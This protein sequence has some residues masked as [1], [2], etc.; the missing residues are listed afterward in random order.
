LQLHALHAPVYSD[1]AGGKTGPQANI[2]IAERTKA[3]RIQHVDE[4]KRT[5]EI[6]ESLPFRYLIQHVGMP[7]EEFD[8]HKIDAAFSSLE[9][10]SVFAR[11]RGVEILLENTSN[12]LSNAEKLGIFFDMTHMDLNVC[13]DTGHAHLTGNPEAE[14]RSL[15]P[16]I[17]STHVHDNNGSDDAH[18][19]PGA[20]GTLDWRGTMQLLRSA[21]GQYPLLLEL[22]EP[23]ETQRPME[24][25]LDAVNLVF[26][27]LEGLKTPHE[28]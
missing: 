16:R 13:F 27:Q 14:F 24:Q 3:K 19:F 1:D 9:E 28:F 22:G 10:I 12:G 4:V 20:G 6:A 15:K 23:P 18:L 2:N 5:L 26:E 25:T 21:P 7:G 17:R 8:L 11:N